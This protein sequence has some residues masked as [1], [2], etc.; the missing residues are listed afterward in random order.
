ME[1]PPLHLLKTNE[2]EVPLG[3]SGVVSQL[4]A[5]DIN[6]RYQSCLGLLHDIRLCKAHSDVMSKRPR[7]FTP[8]YLQISAQQTGD[9]LKDQLAQ[10]QLIQSN[11]KGFFSLDLEELPFPL[12]EKDRPPILRA[13]RGIYGREKELGVILEAYRDSTTTSGVVVT[14]YSGSGKR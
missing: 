10:L 3:L 11:N 8:L 9:Q 2:C 13:I 12:R 4:L 5:K 6:Q 7:T 1:F 14:G